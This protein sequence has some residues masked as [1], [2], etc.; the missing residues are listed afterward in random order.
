MAK[1]YT[2]L[3][4]IIFLFSSLPFCIAQSKITDNKD[5]I[6]YYLNKNEVEIAKD[7]DAV[8]LYESGTSLLRS[9]IMTYKV[10][11]TIKVL[12]QN[13]LPQIGMVAIPA[14]S[15]TTIKKVSGVTYNLEGD[16]IVEQK[17][18]KADIVKD[19]IT[20]NF[21]ALKFN[22]PSMKVGSIV[23]FSYTLEYNTYTG[24]PDWYFQHNFPTVFSMY[25]AS[26]PANY[27]YAD[28]SR[29]NIPFEK[30]NKE[31]DLDGKEAGVYNII[32]GGTK[33]DITTWV[34]RNVPAL[35]DEV[36]RKGE[37]HYLERVKIYITGIYSSWDLTSKSLLKD[38]NIFSRVY[39]ANLF[40]NDKVKKLTNG[41]TDDL[42]KAK[43]IYSF[44]RDNFI[45]SDYQKGDDYLNLKNTFATQK[46][47]QMEINQV[48]ITMLLKAGIN[49]E[50]VI[51]SSKPNEPLNPIFPDFKD[52]DYV[53]T[54]VVVNN[55]DYFL[56]PIQ[57]YLPFGHLLPQC[58]NGYSRIMSKNWREIYIDDKLLQD[59]IIVMATLKLDTS[60]NKMI[61][62]IDKKLNDV[63]AFNYRD[64]W[65]GDEKKAMKVIKEN[66]NNEHFQLENI[67]VKN[68]SE[69]DQD[70]R[71]HIEASADF[72]G[73]DKIFL[74]AYMDRL[75]K[76]NPLPSAERKFPIVFDYE[77]NYN[78]LFNLQL[79]EGYTI[80]YLPESKQIGLE[81]ST[82]LFSSLLTTDESKRSLTL[83]SKFETN[84][85]F[86]EP[87]EYGNMR[88]L[89]EAMLGEQSKSIIIKKEN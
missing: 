52:L 11:R 8:I 55:K 33:S 10:E 70:L 45:L 23:H 51:L 64:N 72:N 17:I 44:V 21:S 61:L 31:K 81:Q 27:R 54:K 4:G 3:I 88:S 59:K 28:M 41:K 9:N 63:T 68:I 60:Q 62:T 29:T 7:A 48:L 24:I 12:N 5:S 25:Q 75:F 56:D 1:L 87:E 66:F 14:Y 32:Y 35:K 69:P 76:T 53:I 36:F 2:I 67:S 37:N 80:E 38:A 30:V 46:G 47:K 71:I 20:D 42:E 39:D 13:A 26:I 57:K 18:D 22:L 16:Q 6:K 58:Y 78:Y 49:A 86:F 34:R 74:N 82:M 65:K 40:A 50:M 84:K 83:N 85:N 73:E 77:F 19:K 89:I 43:S 79:P 15:S